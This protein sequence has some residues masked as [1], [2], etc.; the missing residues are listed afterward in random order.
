M[1]VALLREGLEGD[2]GYREV[3]G[4]CLYVV[5]LWLINLFH[6]LLHFERREQS[7]FKLKLFSD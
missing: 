6:I 3:A 4:D 1:W 5:I 7:M 2:R